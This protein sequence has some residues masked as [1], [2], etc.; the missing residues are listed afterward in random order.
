MPKFLMKVYKIAKNQSKNINL[1]DLPVK[2]ILQ[3]KNKH[4]IYQKIDVYE[5]LSIEDR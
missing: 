1:T 2:S 5:K 3:F 4:L